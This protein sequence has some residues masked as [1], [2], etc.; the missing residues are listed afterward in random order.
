MKFPARAPEGAY[1]RYFLRAKLSER[2]TKTE[3]K[4]QGATRV[5]RK[6]VLGERL[7]DLS[8]QVV[9]DCSFQPIQ[10]RVSQFLHNFA[11]AITC[12]LANAPT[13]WSIIDAR[14]IQADGSFDRSPECAL[15]RLQ[16]R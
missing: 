5:T 3:A 7:T 2:K 6:N 14:K 10:S 13:A 4:L 12:R 1:L 8:G 16:Q 15:F 9:C 11:V